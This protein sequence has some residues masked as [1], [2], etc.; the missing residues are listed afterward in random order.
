MF[1]AT[2]FLSFWGVQ[3]EAE[4]PQYS[5]DSS[6]SMAASDIIISK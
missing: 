5:G 6:D 1:V 2:F 3:D 4:T